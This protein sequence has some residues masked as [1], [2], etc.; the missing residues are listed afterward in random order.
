MGDYIGDHS[1][2]D[3][4]T[5]CIMEVQDIGLSNMF[6][7]MVLHQKI[8]N[9]IEHFNKNFS[10]IKKNYDVCLF[11]DIDAMCDILREIFVRIQDAMLP[12][13]LHGTKQSVQSGLSYNKIEYQ[14]KRF[15]EVN[16]ILLRNIYY[17][18]DRL[19]AMD[20][21]ITVEEEVITTDE[22]PEKEFKKEVEK[23][24]TSRRRFPSKKIRKT[25]T[26]Y[27]TSS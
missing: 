3:K 5:A 15:V 24:K 22:N 20:G 17:I 1:V 23:M 13:V 16:N 21:L 14:Y 9:F 25:H 11:F 2:A 19:E 4:L 12:S 26:K 8:M 18:I 27:W 7:P 10:D 6:N